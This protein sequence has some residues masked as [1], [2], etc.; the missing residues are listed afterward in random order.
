[1]LDSESVGQRIVHFDREMVIDP[2]VMIAGL[3]LG[4]VIIW[5]ECSAANCRD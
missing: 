5:G 1:V 3:F 2:N 4:D